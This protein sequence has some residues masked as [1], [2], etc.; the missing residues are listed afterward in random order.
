MA[1]EQE[2]K[3]MLVYN[4][5]VYHVDEN[6]SLEDKL[7]S[8]FM[9]AQNHWMVLD[10]NP[11]MMGAVLAVHEKSSEEDQAR[12]KAEIDVIKSLNAVISGVPVDMASVLDRIQDVEPIGLNRIWRNV[13]KDRGG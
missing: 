4:E 9:A 1:D 10:E 5:C 8:A 2:V 7:H 13:K 6:D 12:L 3:A 11:Q